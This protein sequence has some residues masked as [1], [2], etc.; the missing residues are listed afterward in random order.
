MVSIDEK[1][2]QIL[3]FFKRCK[4]SFESGLDKLKRKWHGAPLISNVS[5]KFSC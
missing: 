3:G 5:A 1:L 2:K 4:L